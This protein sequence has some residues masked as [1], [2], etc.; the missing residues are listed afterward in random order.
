MLSKTYSGSLG[1]VSD[2]TV[3]GVVENDLA[4]V[5]EDVSGVVTEHNSPRVAEANPTAAG[6]SEDNPAVNL[7]DTCYIDNTYHRVMVRQNCEATS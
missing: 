4:E 1:Q 5:T 6:V 3:T 7:K 2:S